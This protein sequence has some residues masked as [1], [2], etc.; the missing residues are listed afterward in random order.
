MRAEHTRVRV[1]HVKP[2]ILTGRTAADAGGCP[3]P[4]TR[5]STIVHLDWPTDA[6]AAFAT[7]KGS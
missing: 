1:F 6:M 4:V 3:A 5:R 7:V 2:E